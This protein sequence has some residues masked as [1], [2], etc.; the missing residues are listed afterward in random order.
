MQQDLQM[1]DG[2]ITIDQQ[3]LSNATSTI[4]FN[5]SLG[6]NA[7]V[8]LNGNKTLAMSGWVTGDTGVLLVKQGSGTT[9]TVTLPG[10]SV[11]IGGST[12]TTTTASGG[13][14]VLGVYYDGTS[15]YWSIPGGGTGAQGVQGITGAKGAQGITGTKGAQGITGIGAP[16]T[17]GAQGITGQ[18]AG[19]TTY[20]NAGTNRLI[21]GGNTSATIDGVSD[22]TFTGN[23]LAVKNSLDVGSSFTG[24]NSTDGL[25]RAKNDVIAYSTSDK[26]L[27]ENIRP[28]PWAVDK[29]KQIN[30]VYF[31]WTPLTKEE[32]IHI[33]GNEGADI[34]VIAQEIEAILPELVTTRDNG[35]K[36]VKY[37]KMVALLIEAIKEQQGEIE[38]LRR[39]IK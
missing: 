33:H 5:P 25:I 32:K 37:D 20:T 13:T 39:K 12:Y 23:L 34:G 38:E 9:Y 31:D 21:R 10:G 22:L 30:G 27:K 35:Y 24:T 16:G 1:S 26:R 4:T 7:K 15:Y 3:T 11:I 28:I 19:I 2:K 14:D 18:N 36:A 29:V 8:T 17:K 6:S